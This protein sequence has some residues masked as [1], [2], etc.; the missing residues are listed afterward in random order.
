MVFPLGSKYVR[1][2]VIKEV[3]PLKQAGV[4]TTCCFIV[5]NFANLSLTCVEL[6]CIAHRAH[7]AHRP[8]HAHRAQCAQVWLLKNSKIPEEVFQFHKLSFHLDFCYLT[9]KFPKPATN[10]PSWIFIFKFGWRGIKGLH[11]W[12]LGIKNYY[13]I[14]VK[15]KLFQWG[16]NC[17]NRTALWA[18]CKTHSLFSLCLTFVNDYED[19]TPSDLDDPSTYLGGT[20]NPH[21]NHMTNKDF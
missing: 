4:P 10:V 18:C 2:G 3:C 17:Q 16:Q 1:H 13:V 5:F 20:C 11:I 9:K 8:H 21:R 19:E 7:C 14:F 6:Y 12:E 15:Q